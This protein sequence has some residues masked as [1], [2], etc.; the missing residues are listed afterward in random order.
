MPPKTTVII[1]CPKLP[2]TAINAA[3]ILSAVPRKKTLPANSPTLLG[4]KKLTVMPEH[5]ASMDLKKLISSTFLIIIFHLKDS[6]LQLISI[7][8]TTIIS[9]GKV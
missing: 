7:N 9:I 2:I 4:V 6:K 3:F 8:K 5:T 1:V